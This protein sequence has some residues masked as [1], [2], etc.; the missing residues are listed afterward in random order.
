M[1]YSPIGGVMYY[2]L[3]FSKKL[4]RFY[5]YPV[6]KRLKA[7]GSRHLFNFLKRQLCR[8]GNLRKGEFSQ[9]E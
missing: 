3:L 1:R 7:L 5:V 4:S 2:T 9:S 6:A 8:F